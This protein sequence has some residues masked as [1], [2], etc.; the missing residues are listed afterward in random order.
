MKSSAPASPKD[1]ATSKCGA[2]RPPAIDAERLAALLMTG[3][4]SPAAV[5]QLYDAGQLRRE[6]GGLVVLSPRTGGQR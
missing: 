2:P 1:G 6:P 4:D 5:Q 3:D